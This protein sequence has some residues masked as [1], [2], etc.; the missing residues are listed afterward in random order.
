MAST[1]SASLAQVPAL[2]PPPGVE[3]DFK[4]LYS[5]LQPLFI[6]IISIYVVF[7][8]FVVGARLVAKG[9]NARLLQA[10]DCQ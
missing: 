10:E 2:P 5:G 4:T 6:A 3:P 7:S 1:D 8:T 9:L